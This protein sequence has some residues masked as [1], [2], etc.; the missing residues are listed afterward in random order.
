MVLVARVKKLLMRCCVVNFLKF[1]AIYIIYIYTSIFFILLPSVLYLKTGL[2]VYAEL[3][4]ISVVSSFSLFFGYKLRITLPE[5]KVRRLTVNPY[6]FFSV[7]FLSFFIFMFYT[8]YTYGGV[9][10]LLSLKEGS[11]SSLL[12]G[13]LFKGRKGLE[14]GLLYLSAMFTYV[15]IPLALLLGFKYKIRFRTFFLILSLLFCVATLQKALLLNILVPLIAYALVVGYLN[16]YKLFYFVALLF[17]Y[18]IFMISFTGHAGPGNVMAGF[19]LELF[20]SSQFKYSNA[21]QYFVWRVVAVPVYTAVDTLYVFNNYFKS[22]SLLG[23]TSTLFSLLFGVKKV[24]LEKLVFEYQFGGYNPLANANA[25]FAVN[26]FVNFNYIGLVVAS[27]FLG[28]F[29]KV[30]ERSGDLVII[31][32]GYLLAMK[33]LNAPLIGLLFSSGFLYVLLHALILKFKGLG[34]NHAR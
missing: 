17:G 2:D 9:P 20:F 21:V 24:L 27:M 1:K 10:F 19:N 4:S 5:V 33:V 8:F 6:I 23:G 32:M 14:L 18:F 22:E 28:F 26:L 11:D 30:I 25:N 16:G 29:L 3:I 12:R 34:R 15:F 7:V 13:N 31:C